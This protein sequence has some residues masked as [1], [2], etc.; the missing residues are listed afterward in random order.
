MKSVRIR[1]DFT[2]RLPD[3]VRGQVQPGDSLEVLVSGSNVIYRRSVD[4]RSSMREIIE[5][6]RANPP[7]SPPSEAE[8]EAIVHRT[9]RRRT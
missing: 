5:R 8:I 1:S 4:S 2:V 9:R 3:E 7:E 6:V